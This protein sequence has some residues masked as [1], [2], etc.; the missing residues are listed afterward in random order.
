MRDSDSAVKAA[1]VPLGARAMTSETSNSLLPALECATVTLRCPDCGEKQQIDI[2][3]TPRW[4]LPPEC[5]ACRYKIALDQLIGNIRG[6]IERFDADVVEA[7]D[8][9]QTAGF[10][11]M[12]REWNER[13]NS[14]RPMWAVRVELPCKVFKE[15]AGG[16]SIDTP[17]FSLAGFDQLGYVR[18]QI[19]PEA[20]KSLKVVFDNLEKI[21]GGLVEGTT[22]PSAN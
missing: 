3:E 1:P 7:P 18:V 11:K 10:E 21:P 8:A 6:L 2:K 14:G 22:K 13:M 5:A 20:V 12:K 4:T 16:L 9:P 17:T 19:S 15:E